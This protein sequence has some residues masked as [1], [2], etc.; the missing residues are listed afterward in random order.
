MIPGPC[1]DSRQ[2]VVLLALA[3][4]WGFRCDGKLKPPAQLYRGRAQVTPRIK[5]IRKWSLS[6]SLARIKPW[7]TISTATLRLWRQR[8][9]DTSC[10]LGSTS[11]GSYNVI[12]QFNDQNKSCAAGLWV[13]ILFLEIWYPLKV[14]RTWQAVYRQHYQTKIDTL[15]ILSTR[16]LYSFKLILFN[17]FHTFDYTIQRKNNILRK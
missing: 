7:N 17:Y 4:T 1:S 14:S 13:S 5:W 9:N 10:L 2:G 12:C 11:S 8:L 6:S 15:Y 16:T 3:G